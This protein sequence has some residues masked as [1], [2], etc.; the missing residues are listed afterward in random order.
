MTSQQSAHYDSF[1]VLKLYLAET[2]PQWSALPAFAPAH[3]TFLSLL[4]DLD[5]ANA[6]HGTNISGATEGK[7]KARAA[8][9]AALLSLSA[10]LSTLAAATGNYT[11]ELLVHTSRSELDRMSDDAFRGATHRIL[12][13]GAPHAAALRPV[14]RRRGSG[15]DPL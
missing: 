15:A 8:L 6:A 9:T 13:A 4:D 14:A 7:A 11:L 1:Q 10:A 12:R 5:T 2:Q 3:A